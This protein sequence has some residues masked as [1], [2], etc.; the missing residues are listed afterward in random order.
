MGKIQGI[1]HITLI[2]KDINKSSLLFQELFKANEVYS[3]DR[4]N[5][6]LSQEKFLLINDLWVA[7]M[8][9]EPVQRSYQHIA[10]QIE[11]KDLP[12]FA[13]K[14][15]SF[16]LEIQP[17]RSRDPREGESIYFYDYDNHLFELHTGNLEE[18]LNYYFSF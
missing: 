18:R 9:G 13:D 4:K 12:F 16:G 7:L 11:K 17:S 6:S 8:E 2:C 10:F 3:S 15:N 1:S 5:F 14:I